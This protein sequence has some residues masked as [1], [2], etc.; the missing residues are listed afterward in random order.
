MEVQNN[1]SKSVKEKR[2]IHDIMLKT[3][4]VPPLHYNLT[5]ILALMVNT[6]QLHLFQNDLL[7]DKTLRGHT[8]S[9]LDFPKRLHHSERF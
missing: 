1:T 7:D 9:H 5:V 4:S 3:V 8:Q 6:T 2:N